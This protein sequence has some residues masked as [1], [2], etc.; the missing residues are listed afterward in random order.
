MLIEMTIAQRATPSGCMT[1]ALTALPLDC[2]DRLLVLGD[3]QRTTLQVP[4][5]WEL[6]KHSKTCNCMSLTQYIQVAPERL[7]IARHLASSTN[8]T[9]RFRPQCLKATEPV[10]AVSCDAYCMSNA[11]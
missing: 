4:S 10:A 2:K 6:I 1:R 11:D 8:Q 5:V 9:M 3:K 7:R